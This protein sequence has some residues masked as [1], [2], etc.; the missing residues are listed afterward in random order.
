MIHRDIK[1]SNV[2]A[3]TIEGDKPLPKII[4]F[5][6]AKA[7]S[8]RLTEQTIFTEFRQ[9]I[10]TPE[11]MRPEQAGESA[12]DI[13]TRTDVY[14]AGVLL[15]ELLTGATPFDSKRLRSAAY[16]EMQRIIREEDPP[17]PSTRLG[18]LVTT[19]PETLDTAARQRSMPPTKLTSTIAGEL[20]WIVMKAIEKDRARRYDS[21]GSMGADIQRYLSGYAVQAAPPGRAYLVRKFVR[22]NKGPVLAGSLLALALVSGLIGT[23]LGFFNAEQQRK[24]AVKETIRAEQEKERADENAAQARVAEA[25]ATRQAYSASMMSASTAVSGVQYATARAFL[26]AAPQRLRGWEW[27]ALDAKLDSSVRTCVIAAK[28]RSAVGCDLILHPDGRSFF[29][30]DYLGDTVAQRWDLASGRLLQSFSAPDRTKELRHNRAFLSPDGHR[31]TTTPGYRAPGSKSFVVDSWDLSTGERTARTEVACPSEP[32]AR[33][34][35]SRD[36][37]RVF[38]YAG[39]RAWSTRVAPGGTK[40]GAAAPATSAILAERPLTQRTYPQAINRA[41]TVIVEVIDTAPYGLVLSDAQSL[42]PMTVIAW[43]TLVQ[44]V[45]FSN[46]DRWLGITG[47]DDTARVYD[48]AAN[49]PTFVELKHPYQ[50]NNIRFSPDASLVATIAMDR[51]I[52]IWDRATGRLL[53]TYPS[54]TLDPW[55]LMFMQDGKTVAGWESDGTIRFWDVTAEN[56]AVLREHKSIVSS[57]KFAAGNPAGIIVSSSWEGADGS[58]GIVRFWDADSGD[59]VGIYH[60]QLGDIAF[61]MDVSDD[62]RFAAISIKAWFATDRARGGAADEPTGRTDIIDLTTGERVSSSPSRRSPW[63]V[64]FGRD[65]QSVIVSEFDNASNVSFQLHLIDARSGAVRRTTQLDPK[66]EWVFARSP[67]GNT[68]AA[69][70]RSSNLSPSKADRPGTMLILDS[71]TLETVREIDG[72]PEGQKSLAFS[73][74]GARIATGGEDGI[75]RLFAADTGRPLGTT[76]EQGMAILSISFSPDGTRLASAGVDRMIRIWDAATLDPLAAFAGHG[77]HIGCVDWDADGH[78]LVSCSGDYTV[79]V[80]EPDPIRTRIQAREARAAALVRVEPIVAALFDELKDPAAVAERIKTDTSLSPQDRAPG[81][82]PSRTEGH[83]G[84]DQARQVIMLM[85]GPPIASSLA[86]TGAQTEP[87]RSTQSGPSRSTRRVVGKQAHGVTGGGLL[88]LDPLRSVETTRLVRSGARRDGHAMILAAFRA[89][90]WPSR[91]REPRPSRRRPSCR[92]S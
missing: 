29:T 61:G 84:S 32:L 9:M 72:I 16:G 48:L 56:A 76:S 58:T 36:G 79:R 51:A 2:L 87:C 24:V 35:V 85:E 33:T 11:Y 20:D 62:G 25:I 40:T 22:R 26:D 15:Y 46:D 80:W 34:I 83:V 4:D 60:G 18:V 73:P 28:P 5:G 75:V 27:R 3:S 82:P 68:F 47:N 59:E 89:S 10:G 53:S 90:C 21:A 71:Q 64:A 41:D 49:P 86:L 74:D 45:S 7:T 39:D 50:A 30:V 12:E 70:P 81:D 54:E 38:V 55:P 65:H 63:R 6:I 31:L 14:A 57:A 66:A 1:P 92:N 52:R 77:G 44:N 19:K 67:D 23:S 8:A 42:A 43:R 88:L 13:D 37:S 69:L 17:K 78:R 91:R